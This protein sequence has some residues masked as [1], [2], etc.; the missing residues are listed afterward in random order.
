VTIKLVRR[1]RVLVWALGAINQNSMSNYYLL[2][3]T[4]MIGHLLFSK[5]LG[6]TI[7]FLKV[8]NFYYYYYYYYGYLD[9]LTTLTSLEI[10]NHINF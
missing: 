3:N 1:R 8:T 10:N 5:L 2:P 6:A 4:G 7:D 9:T